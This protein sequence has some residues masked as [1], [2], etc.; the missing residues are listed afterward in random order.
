MKE[1]TARHRNVVWIIADQHRAQT[2]GWNGDANVRTPNLDNLIRNGTHFSRAVAGAPWCTPFRGALLTGQYPHQTGV[3]R[4][5]SRLNPSYPTIADAFNRAGYHTAW[6]GKWHLSGANGSSHVVPQEE[7]GRFRYWLGY[8]NNNKQNDV[9]V[10][11]TNCEEPIRLYDYEVPALTR[12]FEDH[13]TA[14]VQG[15]RSPVDVTGEHDAPPNHDGLEYQPFFAVLSVQPP[16][17]PYVPPHHAH[18]VNPASVTLRRNVPPVDWIASRARRDL[19]GYSAMVETVDTT[20]GRVRELLRRLGVDRETY[21]VYMSDHGD[22]LGSH[23]QWEKSSPWEESIRI[24]F[25]V[26]TAGGQE[27]M[28][29]G[30][31]HY[32]L[33][34]V[35]IAPTTL[36]LCGIAPPKDMF[37]YDF[38]PFI[39]VGPQ[40]IETVPPPPQSALL[41]QIPRKYHHHSVNRAWRAVVTRDNWKYVCT[42]HNDWLLHDLNHDPFE[43]ANL[44]YD[45]A[46]QERKEHLHAELARLLQETADDFPLPS[47]DIPKD[48]AWEREHDE[49]QSY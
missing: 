18:G 34:H 7:R 23:G 27:H 1:I 38:S 48:T 16:H 12:L 35:D 4:T 42:P 43:L 41:Q 19:A 47:I 29:V 8:E 6:V 21:I 22:M 45:T 40:A 24:P 39:R 37:G 44:C 3:I 33:N 15:R 10:H 36:G 2:I 20:V 28:H 5:P 26:G 11:G 25:L 31:Y 32:P 17:S 13:V 49:Q 14:H 46:F 9:W 30:E